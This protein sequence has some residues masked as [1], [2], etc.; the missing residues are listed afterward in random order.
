[1]DNKSLVFG[2]LDFKLKQDIHALIFGSQQNLKDFFASLR[3]FNTDEELESK[4]TLS[5][6]NLLL[7]KVDEIK[8]MLEEKADDEVIDSMANQLAE[9]YAKKLMKENIQA[10]CANLGESC[11]N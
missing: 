1:M 9:L 5:V 10:L 7:G 6:K 3:P 8:A 2:A 11:G 4:I